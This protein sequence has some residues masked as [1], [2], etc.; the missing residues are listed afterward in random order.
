M[1]GDK[2]LRHVALPRCSWNSPLQRLSSKGCPVTS[3]YEVQDWGLL[4][5]LLSPLLPSPT[6]P[7]GL[8]PN[9]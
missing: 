5:P 4:S 8:L 7:N 2:R 3:Y 6:T 9:R 1:S